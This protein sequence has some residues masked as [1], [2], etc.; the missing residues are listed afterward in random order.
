MKI[1][2]D[3]G[4]TERNVKRFVGVSKVVAAAVTCR[5]RQE[6][7]KLRQAIAVHELPKIRKKNTATTLRPTWAT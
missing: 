1:E 4:V 3:G 7:L 6:F 5:T 2:S